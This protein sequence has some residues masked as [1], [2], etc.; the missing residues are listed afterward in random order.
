[1]RCRNDANEATKALRS[2]LD[3]HPVCDECAAW[4]GPHRLSDVSN[5]DPNYEYEDLG[6]RTA[7]RGAGPVDRSERA[8]SRNANVTGT[9]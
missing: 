1:M 7:S 6:P 5:V 2:G 3:Y 8:L 4:W 9:P